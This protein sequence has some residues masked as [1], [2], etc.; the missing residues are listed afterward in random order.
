[1]YIQGFVTNGEWNSLRA[2]GL[3]RPVSIFEV[4]A[5]VRRKY[6]RMAVKTMLKMLTPISESIFN[7]I[8]THIV[9]S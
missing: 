1:M 5:Q 3:E 4:R 9:V 6:S 8:C 7:R 2:K